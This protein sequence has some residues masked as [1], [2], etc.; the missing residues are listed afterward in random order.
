MVEQFVSSGCRLFSARSLVPLLLLPAVALAMPESSRLERTIGNQ[1]NRA[2]EW[3]AL[4][5]ALAG[6]AVRCCTVATAPDGTSSRDTRALRAP[7]LNTMGMYSVVRH[8][9]YVGNGLMW[10]GEAASMRVWWLV[11]IV[12]LAY[13][14]YVERIIAF[15]EAFLA[16]S[17]GDEFRAWTSRTPAFVP[18]WSLWTR[19]RGALNWRR[20]ASEHNGLLAVAVAFCLF[21]MPG[22]AGGTSVGRWLTLHRDLIVLL[23]IAVVTSSVAIVARRWPVHPARQSANCGSS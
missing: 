15:E 1:G 14:L 7:S 20:V 9:L 11:V 4:F 23:A 3:A 8:P 10:L 17:F 12:A 5:I 22:L 18:R 16:E 19:A 13:A 6:V 2:L 21:Q